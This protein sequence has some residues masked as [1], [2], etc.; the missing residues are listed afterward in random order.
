VIDDPETN[1]PDELPPLPRV[2]WV[3][4]LTALI[5]LFVFAGLVALVLQ[6]AKNVGET[7]AA[8]GEQQLQELRARERDILDNFGYDQTTKTWRIPIDQAMGILIEEGKTKGDMRS[9]PSPPK[10]APKMN[11]QRPNP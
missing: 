10:P 5:I 4:M 7:P 3:T 2:P 11:N 6:Y 9:F 1:V 8:S